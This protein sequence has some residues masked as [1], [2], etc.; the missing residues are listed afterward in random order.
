MVKVFEGDSGFIKINDTI[1][2]LVDSKYNIIDDHYDD[3]ESLPPPKPF[4]KFHKI[5][6]VGDEEMAA[7]LRKQCDLFF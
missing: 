2:A 6:E 7:N 5:Y 1:T 4:T 3:E